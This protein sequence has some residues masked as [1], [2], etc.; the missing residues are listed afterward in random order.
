MLLDKGID[1][2]IKKMLME[3]GCMQD[4]EVW[5]ETNILNTD[6]QGYQ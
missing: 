2:R 3:R 6:I 5:I 4:I 1:K